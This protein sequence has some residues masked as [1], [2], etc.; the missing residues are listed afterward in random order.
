MFNPVETDLIDLIEYLA[1]VLRPDVYLE[2]GVYK[3]ETISRVLKFTKQAI[4]VDAVKPQNT[5]GF[6]FYHMS[7]DSFFHSVNCGEITI[8]I[9]DMVFVDACHS[10][11]QSLK[12][13]NN[14]FNHVSDGGLIFL[15]DTYPKNETSII[16]DCCGDTYR[17]AW[18]IRMNHNGCEIVTIPAGPGMSIIRKT[19]RQLLWK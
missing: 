14:V 6:L 12:D 19:S 1:S 5:I 10:Y 7:T 3:A 9:L 15:H 16:P 4:G 11:E 2:L 13:F 18:E 8:P 17:T